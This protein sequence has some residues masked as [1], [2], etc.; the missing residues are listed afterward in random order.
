MHRD[1]VSPNSWKYVRIEKW[2][3]KLTFQLHYRGQMGYR[4]E[5]SDRAL[6]SIK[7]NALDLIPITQ[8]TSQTNKRLVLEET[9][10]KVNTSLKKSY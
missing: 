5:L 2:S 4:L 3:H 6:L 10:T 9:L 7:K 8:T 1:R